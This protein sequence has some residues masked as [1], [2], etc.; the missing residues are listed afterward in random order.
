ME[1]T[2]QTTT[3]GRLLTA[4]PAMA[5]MLDYESPEELMRNVSNIAK[6]L[7]VDPEHR[8]EFKRLVRLQDSISGFETRMYRK[9]G[10]ELPV[11]LSARVIRSSEG[12]LAG[13]E[14]M[15][16]DI[17]ERKRAEEALREIR[18][19]ERRR[20]ARDLHDVVLQDLT[21]TLQSMR[22]TRRVTDDDEW[23]QERDRQVE[24]L[25][26]AVAGLRNAIYDLRV[27]GD[28]EQPLVRSLES[29]VD[30][31][32]QMSPER[33]ISFVVEDGF[34]TSLTGGNCVEV[35]RI[36]QEALTNVR[37]HSEARN[38]VVTIGSDGEN[39]RVEV[40]DD[41]K[42]FDLTASRGVG[43][44]GMEERVRAFDGDL[45]IKSGEEEG[46]RIRISFALAS[47]E[48]DSKDSIKT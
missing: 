4:N 14:G 44:V 20:I 41:G 36:I 6:Q 24:S 43:I 32:R 15:M 13:Y 26:G 2:F 48:K 37:R 3:D 47:V 16:E 30:L 33:R 40:E 46:T 38:V 9:D 27:E 39:I 19:A 42:G 29:L 22:V 5:R 35:V 28:R 1:G 23:S 34:P 25:R 45:E 11:S 7:Y 21:Y 12:E 18:E 17:T 31:N 8:E 10:S